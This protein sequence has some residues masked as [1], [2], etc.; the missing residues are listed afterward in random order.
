MRS[1]PPGRAPAGVRRRGARRGRGVPAVRGVTLIELVV[2]LAL[3]AAVIG[4]IYEF[5]IW[6]ARSATETNDFMQSQAQVR[7]ALDNIVDEARWANAVTA[8]TATS[9]TLQ[10]AQNTPFLQGSGPYT[11]TFAY[12]AAN[13]AVTRQVGAG[14][15]VPLAYLVAG[16]N[17]TTGLTFTYFDNGG[18]SLG[19]SPG[20][21]Q[22]G[23]IARVRATVATTSGSVTRYLAG[24]AALRAHP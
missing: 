19:S 22:L 24:D 6:G 5:V 16:P 21:G 1:N 13:Q 10:V 23:S 8:A 18:A 11:V 2:M 17:S 15:P 20:A 7:A 12:D 14:T 4:G 3:L 9:V